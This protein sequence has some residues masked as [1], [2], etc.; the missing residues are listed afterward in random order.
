[1]YPATLSKKVCSFLGPESNYRDAASLLDK[2]D[3]NP[4]ILFSFF[5]SAMHSIPWNKAN[6]GLR[7]RIICQITA[8]I[9]SGRLPFEESIA[10]CFSI[11]QIH[12]NLAGVF[13]VS[14]FILETP[15]GKMYLSKIILMRSSPVL[16]TIFMR[17]PQLGSETLAVLAPELEGSDDMGLI[18]N[19]MAFN[20]Y[21]DFHNLHATVFQ[22]VINQCT[23]WGCPQLDNLQE[24]FASRIYDFFTAC[25]NLAY[26]RF[27]GLKL[28]ESRSISFI[29]NIHFLLIEGPNFKIYT[30]YLPIVDDSFAINFFPPFEA[31]QMS[32]KLLKSGYE[33][34]MKIKTLQLAMTVRFKTKLSV[35][36]IP[37]SN[38]KSIEAL[39]KAIDNKPQVKFNSSSIKTLI[40]DAKYKLED[41][42]AA[43]MLLYFHSVQRV[44]LV[45]Y[46]DISS[47]FLLWLS[48]KNL[49]HISITDYKGS[50]ESLLP[51]FPTKLPKVNSIEISFIMAKGEGINSNAITSLLKP[52]TIN[53]LQLVNVSIEAPHD[54]R[55]LEH[56]KGLAL[57]HVK[58]S[59]EVIQSYLKHCSNLEKMYL[60]I[61]ET[62]LNLPPSLKKLAICA[63][64]LSRGI[65]KGRIPCLDNLDSLE[66]L[67][68]FGELNPIHAQALEFYSAT[69]TIE[70]HYFNKFEFLDLD[71]L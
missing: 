30:L 11:F 26:A 51:L 14:D 69:R 22:R 55:V 58:A 36:S 70:L 33:G 44:E 37:C 54:L 59:D 66:K 60:N 67:V 16:Q 20:D 45:D 57:M 32:S 2:L 35:A 41:I 4:E 21:S 68:V 12:L 53:I 62:K 38:L 65:V 40:F 49:N 63:P 27:N 43:G 52:G 34:N 71:S 47:T 24:I 48:F 29:D 10:R 25:S 23:R 6:G 3:E 19:I 17:N 61:E 42:I 46:A 1:M 64:L 28:L 7:C 5:N 9:L 39:K 50:F 15:E 18:Y 56:L 8:N 13:S 31:V